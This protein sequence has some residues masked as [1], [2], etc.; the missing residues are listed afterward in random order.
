MMCDETNITTIM[1][2]FLTM[3]LIFTNQA[4]PFSSRMDAQNLQKYDVWRCYV[5][6]IICEVK[7]KSKLV[8]R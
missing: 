8:Y 2:V 3:T 5:R 4:S 7:D 6:N 1:F